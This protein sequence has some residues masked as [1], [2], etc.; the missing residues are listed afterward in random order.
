MPRVED[1]SL[2]ALFVRAVVAM[3]A[4]HPYDKPLLR[5]G[6]KLHDRF[7]LPAALDEDLA[8]V[9]GDLSAAGLHFERDW[10]DAICQTRFPV[11]GK[12]A[13]DKGEVTVRQALEPWPL[14]AETA[15]GGQTSRMVD[16][17]TDRI[18][19]SLSSRE[20]LEEMRILVNGVSL[21]FFE[22]GE[23]LAAGVRY[24]AA[25]GWPALHPHVPIQSPLSIEVVDRAGA[26]VAAAQYHFWNPHGPRYRGAPRS[27]EEARARRVERWR[28]VRL[29]GI[30]VRS[31]KAP[32][33]SD[34]S[35]YTLD[36]RRQAVMRRG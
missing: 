26:V 1:Q 30:E 15:S 11:L 18:E 31:P 20:L 3:L 8:R 19:V 16:N 9:C 10:F 32:I 4:E 34:D 24:K 35:Y 12:L 7:M 33:Y 23:S 29:D 36:L 17:S 13:L 22:I 5:H 27:F 6:T 14:M 25:A 21:R 2:C 28:P